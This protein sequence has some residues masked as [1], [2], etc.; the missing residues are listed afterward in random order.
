MDSTMTTVFANRAEAGRALVKLLG[1]YAARDDVVVLG[2]P[3]GGV[4]VA[5]EI[6]RALPADL[7][8]L[9]VRKLGVPVQPELAMGAIASGGMLYVDHDV[10]R[11][12][13]VT[14]AEF[15][16]VL[17][18]ERSELSRREVSYGDKRRTLSLEGRVAIV[19]DDGM[20]TGATMKAAVMALRE[21]KP[22]RV[23]A[24]LPVIPAD[25]DAGIEEG[26]DELVCVLR[27]HNYFGVGQF[28]RDFRQTDDTEVFELLRQAQ[29]DQHLRKQRNYRHDD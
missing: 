3:R 2:L 21:K 1:D 13:G 18:Q 23:V 20:A 7:D 19:V 9:I 4:P 28:Y 29:T 14:K 26:V 8:V 10:V 17:A 6:A 16:A 15:D 22:S 12:M 24:A 27:P 25:L 11:S 5:F